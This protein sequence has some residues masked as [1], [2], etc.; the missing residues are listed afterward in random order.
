MTAEP[1][2]AD[3]PPLPER[4]AWE[5]QHG[6]SSQAFEAFRVYR[7]LGVNRSLSAVASELGKNRSLIHEWSSKWG[8]V[9][10]IAEWEIES[11]RLDRARQAELRDEALK[12]HAALGAAA[13]YTALQRLVGENRDG[14][15]PVEK[16]D[17]ND[18][19]AAEVA[20]LMREGIRA[21]R[22]AY[23][24]PTDLVRGAFMV[25]STDVLKIVSQMVEV[26]LRY[27]P[28]EVEDA[29]LRDVRAISSG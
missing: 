25:S 4:K 23:G 6:E 17:P 24:E 9:A 26:A 16:L 10:R 27:I 13:T 5:R 18:L 14:H 21:E 3:K 2:P 8:W 20:A 15:E 7:D 12:R 11:D 22:M 29:Y 1:E 28:E 19:G